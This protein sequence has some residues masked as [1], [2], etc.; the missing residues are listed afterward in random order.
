M[1]DMISTEI[2]PTCG[3]CQ[4]EHPPILV[5]T[6][7]KAG[8]F[9]FPKLA[10]IEAGTD[11]T[12]LIG[13]SQGDAPENQVLSAYVNKLAATTAGLQLY[14]DYHS[15][16]QLFMTRESLSIIADICDKIAKLTMQ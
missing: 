15:Y 12:P 14:I 10:I 11:S 16:S 6:I 8:R 9:V 7:L 4:V 2:G 5:P 3:R 13:I 1:S